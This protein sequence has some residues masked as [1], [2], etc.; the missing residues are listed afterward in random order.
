[1]LDPSQVRLHP[2]REDP[3]RWL[4][5]PG[6]EYL[7]EKNLSDQSVGVYKEL[8]D[9]INKYFEA[10]QPPS[11]LLNER[12]DRENLDTSSET[13]I[14][15]TSR[16]NELQVQKDYALQ[17]VNLLK[18]QLDAEVKLR[19]CLEEK[20][21]V[22][23]DRQESLRQELQKSESRERYFRNAAL[24]YSQEIA[25]VAPAL[26]KLTERTYFTDAGFI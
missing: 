18:S 12:L 2:V 5:R 3:Y 24:D 15:F 22:A 4:V 21:Q 26:T 17:E 1:M 6:K 7:F 9:G 11:S 20:L 10:T 23:Y 8:Y 19:L 13:T 25:K 14:T 16:I